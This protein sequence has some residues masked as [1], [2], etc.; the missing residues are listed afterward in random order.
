[1]WVE[2]HVHLGLCALGIHH[3]VWDGRYN[4]YGMETE[5]VLRPMGL[6]FGTTFSCV[7]LLSMLWCQQCQELGVGAQF[8]G[9]YF[10]HD[11]RVIRL[12]RH[13]A[14]CPVGLGVSCSADR[15]AIVWVHVLKCMRVCFS[16]PF[17]YFGLIL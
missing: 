12:P 1:M 9:K 6:R 4:R 17:L 13:G 16:F 7:P 15:C 2:L 14:S 5:F 8:G 10:A 3:C 11:V